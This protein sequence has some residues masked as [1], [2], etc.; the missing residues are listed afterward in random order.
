MVAA[1]DQAEFDRVSIALDARSPL[2]RTTS[3][4]L[5]FWTPPLLSSNY[6]KDFWRIQLS[7][8]VQVSS[9]K[10]DSWISSELAG[11]PRSTVPRESSQF[12][13]RKLS[14]ARSNPATPCATEGSANFGKAKRQKAFQ[15]DFLDMRPLH[16]SPK[17]ASFSLVSCKDPQRGYLTWDPN[18]PTMASFSVVSLCPIRGLLLVL[19]QGVPG[20]RVILKHRRLG[21]SLA[22]WEGEAVLLPHTQT[23]VKLRELADAGFKQ[24][25]T[26]WLGSYSHHCLPKDCHHLNSVNHSFNW[27]W[28]LGDG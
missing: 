4:I 27:G 1:E 25:L 10:S 7:D 12:H 13:P 21:A 28:T 3:C 22:R 8:T 24:A 17:K 9:V 14:E 6:L 16:K 2:I 15:Y 19:V 18:P 11:T 5:Y 23:P 26:K 20:P